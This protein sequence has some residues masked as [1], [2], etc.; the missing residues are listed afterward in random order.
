MKPLMA[1]FISVL[2]DLKA[3]D[4]IEIGSKKRE[5]AGKRNRA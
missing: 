5:S 2:P 1:G 4:F 3:S